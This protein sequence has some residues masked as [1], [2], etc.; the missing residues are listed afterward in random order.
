MRE[1]ERTT[2][3]DCVEVP[4]KWELE[5][6]RRNSNRPLVLATLG[7][8]FGAQIV[9]T[10]ASLAFAIPFFMYGREGEGGAVTVGVIFFMYYRLF[11]DGF[12]GRSLGKRLT[13]T[14]VIETRSKDACGLWKSLVRNFPLYCCLGIFDAIFI[15]GKARKRVGDHLAGTSVV[16][17]PRG[18]APAT[19]NISGFGRGLRWMFHAAVLFGAGA[20]LVQDHH[21]RTRSDVWLINA[22]PV[23][24]QVS[25]ASEVH[26]VAAESRLRVDDVEMGDYSLLV[27]SVGGDTLEEAQVTIPAR[28]DLVAWNILDAAP[29]YFGRECYGDETVEELPDA[30][31]EDLYGDPFIEIE[32]V[33]YVFD[34]TPEEILLDYGDS[35]KWVTSFGEYDGGWQTK[36]GLLAHLEELDLVQ[37]L[38]DALLAL[39]TADEDLA[40]DVVGAVLDVGEL[41]LFDAICEEAFALFPESRAIHMTRQ[42]MYRW[43]SEF[44]Q[45]RWIYR[46]AATE[47]PDSALFAFLHA[48]V[49]TLADSLAMTTK[50]LERFPKDPWILG[51]HAWALHQ[52]GDF[53]G[54]QESFD[55]VL[56]GEM[57]WNMEFVESASRNLV[58]L[59]RAEEALELASEF[60]ELSRP[61]SHDFLVLF[62]S[63]HYAA[64]G[65]VDSTELREA[66]TDCYGYHD[67]FLRVW[68]IMAAGAPVPDGVLR[69]SLGDETLQTA[70]DVARALEIGPDGL[71]RFFEER[72]LDAVAYLDLARQV[73][74][75]ESAI[76]ADHEGLGVNVLWN[77][78]L[79]GH[80]LEHGVLRDQ[81]TAYTAEIPWEVRAVIDLFDARESELGGQER[82]ELVERARKRDFMGG[83]A[84]RIAPSW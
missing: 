34:E 37:E 16:K 39:E 31:V 63:L 48:R 15:F 8:R 64:E 73:A 5:E 6:P 12:S 81:E 83:W 84:S 35:L 38:A 50:D 2:D 41:E 11:C 32:E 52:T 76:A 65:S 69:S 79:P 36:L 4:S 54:A 57:L 51:R 44:D 27:R 40:I 23:A 1:T 17:L 60:H 30:V 18:E 62:A 75:A 33:D 29:L 9:D 47:D 78:P 24:V 67:E 68:Y 14:Q 3:Q 28:H 61:G 25:F 20:L 72:V 70:V 10:V 56:S 45:I 74:F 42:D 66:I 53:Q 22:L 58:A 82:K 71:T 19:M 49:S 59:G 46:V 7:E 77:A 26:F 43:Y 80:L 21:D 55:A 13:G